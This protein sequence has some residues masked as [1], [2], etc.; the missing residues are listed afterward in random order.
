MRIGFPSTLTHEMVG[1]GLPLARQ[2]SMMCIPSL[3]SVSELLSS[4]NMSGGTAGRK[5]EKR[6]WHDLT[7]F[8]SN[9]AIWGDLTGIGRQLQL[10][11]NLRARE[12]TRS[13]KETNPR[14]SIMLRKSRWSS[15]YKRASGLFDY[16]F[17]AMLQIIWT[18]F[19]FLISFFKNTRPL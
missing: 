6:E 7:V 13:I 18:F 8:S 11:S 2:L 1:A 10:G 17:L 16:F 15:Q 19:T 12:A 9:W 5:R 14:P 3:A 4:S